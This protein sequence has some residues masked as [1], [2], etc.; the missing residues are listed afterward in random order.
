[1]Q[2]QGGFNRGYERLRS[3]NFEK[4]TEGDLKEGFY[5]GK[6]LPLDNPN[7]VARKFSQGPNKYP[8]EI[9]DAALFR[10]TIDSYHAAM[11]D[12]AEKI[13]RILAMSLEVDT[14]WFAEFTENPVAVLRL[15]HYP[16][17]PPDASALE[18]GTAANKLS[19]N[20]IADHSRNWCSYRFRSSHDSAPGF[21][22]WLADL[23]PWC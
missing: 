8:A 14:D 13:L 5:F 3:Q 6:D 15:L 19:G 1:M 20:T 11:T 23:G 21:R 7:V 4:K 10:E 18:R 16:P 12:L 2:D 17:Q 9:S 22:W